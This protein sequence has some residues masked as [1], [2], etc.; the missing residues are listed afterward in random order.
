MVLEASTSVGLTL[1]ALQVVLT[2]RVSTQAAGATADVRIGR[3][4]RWQVAGHVTVS[5]RRFPSI[6][7][8]LN[9][10]RGRGPITP[11]FPYDTPTDYRS[12]TAALLVEVPVPWT[13]ATGETSDTARRARSSVD[14]P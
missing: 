5:P 9:T 6:G 14:G 7:L 11:N 8:E 13:R 1:P 2:P 4:D 10:A 12:T 3:S